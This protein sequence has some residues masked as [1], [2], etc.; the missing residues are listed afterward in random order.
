[1]IHVKFSIA[2]VIGL[3]WVLNVEKLLTLGPMVHLCAFL[4]STN[5]GM[6]AFRIPLDPI[7][8]LD[9]LGQPS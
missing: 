1:M 4:R 2:L 8:H 5:L 6:F 9:P 7:N 3:P